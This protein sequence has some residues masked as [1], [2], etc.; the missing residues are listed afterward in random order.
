M[1][2]RIASV[3]MSEQFANIISDR[4]LQREGGQRRRIAFSPARSLVIRMAIYLAL[5]TPPANNSL[6]P[7]SGRINYAGKIKDLGAAW[8]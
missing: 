4:E 7:L 6:H 1:V 5:F 2:M 8:P 3:N